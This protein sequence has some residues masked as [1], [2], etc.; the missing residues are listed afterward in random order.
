MHN[1]LAPPLRSVPDENAGE[2]SGRAG[3]CPRVFYTSVRFDDAI[4]RADGNALGGIVMALAFDTGSLI[5]HIGDAIAFA[6]GFC[7]ALWY[8]RATGDAVFSNFHGHDV[9][10]VCEFTN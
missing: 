5:D 9:Y 3:V 8:T 10:S 1:S 2:L 4:D 6:N 7:R